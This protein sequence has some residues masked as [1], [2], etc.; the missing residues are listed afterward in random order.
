MA[1]T[2]VASAA[3]TQMSPIRLDSVDVVFIV[4]PRLSK[5]VCQRDLA[6]VPLIPP[7]RQAARLPDVQQTESSRHVFVSAKN[8][9]DATQVSCAVS[10]TLTSLQEIRRCQTPLKPAL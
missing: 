10:A 9:I 1:V 5:D 2:R 6:C 7:G 8:E 3:S 4:A